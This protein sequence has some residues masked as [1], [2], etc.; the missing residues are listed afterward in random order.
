MADSKLP[1][2][3]HV[4]DTSR[5]DPRNSYWRNLEREFKHDINAQHSYEYATSM[6]DESTPY[7]LL[8][9]R[10]RALETRVDELR[11]EVAE[12]RGELHEAGMKQ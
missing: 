4:I 10:I 9:A 11:A 8:L 2:H 12:L 1:S 5:I 3:H 6:N 7:S